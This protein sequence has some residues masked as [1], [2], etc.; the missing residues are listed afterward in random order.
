MRI[1][2]SDLLH[3]RIKS[4][5][6]SQELTLDLEPLKDHGVV[7]A[8]PVQLEGQ[9][10][11]VDDDVLVDVEYKVELK[12]SCDRCLKDVT[13]TVEG[14]IIRDLHDED[15]DESDHETMQILIDHEL[16]LQFVLQEELLLNMPMQVLCDPDC[17]G[18]CPVCGADLNTDP[19]D[20]DSEKIDPRL[21]GLKDFFR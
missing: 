3:G 11:N 13:R 16:D 4:I 8:G 19:C 17:Q 12:Y 5:R 15:H 9:V 6:I 14:R 10:Y 18:L 7:N 1:N 21:E 2:V 20:C